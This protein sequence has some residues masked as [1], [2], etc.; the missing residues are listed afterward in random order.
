[1]LNERRNRISP[2]DST[3]F[4]L[5]LEQLSIDMDSP[6]NGTQVMDLS[7]KYN[8]SVYDAAYLALAMRERVPLSTLDKDLRNAA[9]AAG[10]PLLE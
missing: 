6:R 7:R 3:R 1:V 9:R 8:L 5:E 2:D 10:V 4:L